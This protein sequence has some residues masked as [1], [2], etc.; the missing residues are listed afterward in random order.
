MFLGCFFFLLRHDGTFGEFFGSWDDFFG[1]ATEENS[2]SLLGV[3]KITTP[4]GRFGWSASL[5]EGIGVCFSNMDTYT[6]EIRI[7]P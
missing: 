7:K 5:G 2:S 6:T 4:N 1:A 3:T